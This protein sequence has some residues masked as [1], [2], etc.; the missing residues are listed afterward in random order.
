MKTIV[1]TMLAGMLSFNGGDK[2]ATYKTDNASSTMKIL[3][4]ST[5]HDWEMEARN[6]QGVMN[7]DIYENSLE[8]ND[9]KL[10]IEVESLKS[11]KSAMD[12][13]AHEA[14]KE[15][16]HPKIHYELVNVESITQKGN[17]RYS[18]VTKGKL[19]IAGK[20]RTMSI[21][22][23][24]EVENGALELIGKTTFNMS[25]FGVEPPSFMFGSVTTGDEITIKFNITYK[26]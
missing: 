20:T 16:D 15:D 22:L 18:L 8:I 14:L 6:M 7:V 21:P 2:I 5:M 1:L 25:G 23:T 9:L 19:T 17:N 26:S 10:T 24:A 3:G 4:T 11:G 13:N 12:N